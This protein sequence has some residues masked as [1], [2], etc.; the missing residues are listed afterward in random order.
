MSALNHHQIQ[1]KLTYSTSTK[2]SEIFYWWL[3]R[4]IHLNMVIL[5]C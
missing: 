2:I 4:K 1:R 5:H 3:L